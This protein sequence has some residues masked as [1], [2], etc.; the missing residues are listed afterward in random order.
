M[1]RIPTL[2]RRVR[3]AVASVDAF[4]LRV[5][6]A[7]SQLAWREIRKKGVP[8]AVEVVGDPWDALSPGGVRTLLRPVFRRLWSRNQELMCGEASAASYV[9]RAA[10]QRRYPP[11][12]STWTASVSSIDLR[13]GLVGTDKLEARIAEL[14]RSRGRGGSA[15]RPWRVA[16]L[17]TLTSLYKGPDVLLNAVAFCVKGCLQL[18]VAIAGEGKCRPELERLAAKLGLTGSARFLGALPAG[19]PVRALLDDTDLFVLPSRTEGLPRSLIEAMAR[20]CPCIGSSVGGIPELLP[21]EDMVRPGDADALARKIIE[22]LGDPGRME[23]MARRN[24]EAARE[25]LPEILDRRRREFYTK[26]RELSG[27]GPRVASLS[28]GVSEAV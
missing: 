28:S 15:E 17:G 23:R 3:E 4:I 16:F 9:T 20:G 13:D 6:G 2:R 8:F 18:D 10:L 14:R 19:E 1:W 22:V 24:W 25:Y 12:P 26:I 11:G 5:P 27:R 21:P 7:I